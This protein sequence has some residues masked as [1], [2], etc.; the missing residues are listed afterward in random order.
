MNPV[1]KVYI[2]KILPFLKCGGQ[3]SSIKITQTH[4][5]NPNSQTSSQQDST[6]AEYEPLR[7]VP[8]NLYF[9]ISNDSDVC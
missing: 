5:S 1:L 8:H 2:L 4:V 3:I 7:L 6:T 9:S